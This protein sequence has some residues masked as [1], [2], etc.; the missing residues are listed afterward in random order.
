MF[1]AAPVWITP[2]GSLGTIVEQEFY[3][4]ALSAE[5]TSLFS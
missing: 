3:T 2:P 4:I 5:N 1:M